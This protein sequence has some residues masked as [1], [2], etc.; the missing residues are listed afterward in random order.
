[1]E[2]V[3][4]EG[5]PP[6]LASERTLPEPGETYGVVVAVVV[7]AGYDS[8]TLTDAEVPDEFPVAFLRG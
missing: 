3:V 7:E 5:E 1:M 8:D 2:Y 4:E 6:R